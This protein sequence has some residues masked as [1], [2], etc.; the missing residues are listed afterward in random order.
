MH[1][2]EC[3]TL[4]ANNSDA[5]RTPLASW[6]SVLEGIELRKRDLLFMAVLA[7]LACAIRVYSL[8]FFHVIS[9][10]G[11]SYVGAARALALGEPAG[12]GTYGFYSV[13]IWIAGWFINDLELAG[14][15]V[16]IVCGS[17]LPVAYFLAGRE[18]FPRRV[19]LCAS[20]VAVAWP[21]LVS[22]SCEVMTQASYDLIQLTGIYLLWRMF[23]R[24]AT[25][26]GVL[27]GLFV[28]LTY[29]TR[30]EGVLLF[31]LAPLP[32]LLFH[33]REVRAHWSVLVAYLVSFS[34][35]FGLNVLLVHHITGEWQLSAKTDSALNDALSYYLNLPDLNYIPGYE[36]KGYLEILRDHPLFIVENSLKNIREMATILPLW[37]WG[38]MGIGFLADGFKGERNLVR[39]FLLTTLAPLGVL[40]VFYY[41]S[42]GYTEAYLP[43]LFFWGAA[44]LCTLEGLATGKLAG[45][46]GEE[47]HRRVGRLSL[48]VV[49][50]LLYSLQLFSSQVRADVP[51]SEYQWQSDNGRR[52]E[53]HIGLLL[54]ANLPPGKI[55]TRWA[56]I[57]F[58]AE[59][60]WVNIPAG[61]EFD[62]IIKTARDNGVRFLVADG[63]LFSNRPNLGK[64]IFEPLLDESIPYGKYFM[65]D[66]SV[67][68][69]GL[70][71][72]FLY[73]DPQSFGVVVY[74]IPPRPAS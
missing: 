17:L 60:E 59:R 23:R 35:L 41:V 67:K 22:S 63:V 44:G 52:A 62:S 55:M 64:E 1:R 16:S 38:L 10:D 20:L 7:L 74:E 40:I 47:W 73:T 45:R 72:F 25:L 46:L 12:I 51:D 26:T 32:L 19:A 68:I 9:T 30:P 50:A 49:L 4:A 65:N 61:V 31:L 6:L 2:D 11:T 34:L 54:K 57:A 14:R 15:V 69:R 36:P 70:R 3:S 37:F 53:K 13:L 71:P 43:A 28:G 18:L 8:Q 29:L 33:R 27:A 5:V 48:A 66:Q 42:P 39:L 58:Y 24:P 56:R 21:P